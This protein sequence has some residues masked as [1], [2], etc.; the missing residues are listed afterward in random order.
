MFFIGVF[1]IQN[2][3]E[4]IKYLND[5]P[6]R[7]CDKGS[8]GKLIKTFNFFHFF[9]IPIFKWNAKYYVICSGCSSLYE[10]PQEKGK[11]I[12]RGEN[13]DI[14]YW[15]LRPVETGHT[16]SASNICGHCGKAVE[17]DYEYCPYCGTKIRG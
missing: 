17:A 4:E 13:I 1:G 14:S 9:F 6:C 5:V 11:G 8:V 12:E 2:K 16:H 15:D 3:Q 10:I 7:N